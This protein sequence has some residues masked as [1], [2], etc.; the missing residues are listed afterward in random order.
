MGL[1]ADEQE[2]FTLSKIE[3]NFSNYSAWHERTRVLQQV[4]TERRTLS[5][6]ELLAKPA[7]SSEEPSGRT[8][9]ETAPASLHLAMS[10]ALLMR[11]NA[12]CCYH[13]CFLRLN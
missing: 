8:T 12:F 1:S 13:R 4:N 11:R 9:G 2:A 7:A 6:A 5:L 3:D 10:V